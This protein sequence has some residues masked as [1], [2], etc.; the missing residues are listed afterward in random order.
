[1]DHP[2]ECDHSSCT[3]ANASVSQTLSEMDWERGLWH[4]AF[5]GDEEKVVSLISKA[6]NSKVTVN[7]P[8]NAGYTPLHYAARKGYVEICKILIQNGALI[9]AQTKSGL[10][11]PL[12]K[13][14]VAGKIETIKFLIQSGARVDIQD[15]DRQTILHKAIENKHFDLVNYLVETYPELKAMTDVK[16]RCATDYMSGPND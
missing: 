9:D 16:G 1:M 7:S 6:R 15:A 11:T 5:Y 13:A 8:D 12:H 10:A 3:H 4:A 2:H 14:A